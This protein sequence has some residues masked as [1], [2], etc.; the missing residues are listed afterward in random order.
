MYPS[1]LMMQILYCLGKSMIQNKQLRPRSRSHGSL[2][3][4]DPPQLAPAKYNPMSCA[5]GQSIVVTVTSIAISS[6][7]K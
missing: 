7:S 5:L 1:G 2:A 4:G 3:D 6:K